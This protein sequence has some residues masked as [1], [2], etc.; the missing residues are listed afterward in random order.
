MNPSE[1]Q[2]TVN[3]WL[4]EI[5]RHLE[6]IHRSWKELEYIE[7]KYGLKA[8]NIYVS[9]WIEIMPKGEK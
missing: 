5:F 7:Q 9:T 2:A 8:Q 6:D 4:H 1:Q 3:V